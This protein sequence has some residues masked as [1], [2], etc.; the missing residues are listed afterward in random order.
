MGCAVRRALMARLFTP[1]LLALLWLF[2]RLPLP[3]LAL[4]GRGVGRLTWWLAGS[5]R[6]VAL[7]NLELCL[8]ELDGSRRHAIAREH[9]ALAGRG[10]LEHALSWYASRE[11]LMRLIH[12]EGDVKLAERSARPVMWLVPHFVGL[13][14]ASLAV[15]LYQSRRVVS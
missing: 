7:R 6:A 14:I 9:F 13:D 5:R 15:Q 11:R 1:L 8:P 2:S 10:L 12:V 4:L 3:A